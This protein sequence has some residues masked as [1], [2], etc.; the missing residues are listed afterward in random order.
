MVVL[1]M[2]AA[3]RLWRHPSARVALALGGAIGASMLIRP[4][5]GLL[6]LLVAVPV[7]LWRRADP[8]RT[9]VARLAAVALSAFVVV[10]PWAAYN[11]GRFNQPVMLSTGLGI[12]LANTNCDLTY[13]G[14]RVGYWSPACIPEI[15]RPPGW[16]Q[17]DDE[18]FLR[19]RA[20][21][22]IRSHQRR[23]PVVVAARIGRMW[24]LY[25]PLQQIDLDFW[26][27]RPV[28][29][30]RLAL[31]VFYPMAMLAAAGAIALRR[32]RLPLSPLLAPV[33]L[34][35]VSAVITF[36]H[37][38]YRAPAEV[39][40]CILAAVGATTI[41]DRLRRRGSHRDRTQPAPACS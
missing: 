23:F 2:W 18:Q 37:A 30:S 17:S 7:T 8:W 12:T 15:P 35:T 20:I 9:R 14:D 19:E 11:L 26:E 16:D 10:L 5:S 41:L 34:V 29:A 13:Y 33:V 39:S 24:N 27:G 21:D 31:G 22:Y 28:W 6:V 38:R 36:G 40:L 3:Y 32:R 1:V 25:K 4:E